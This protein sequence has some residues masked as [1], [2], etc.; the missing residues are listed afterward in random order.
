MPEE[1]LDEGHLDTEPPADVTF[2]P[3]GLGS[4]GDAAPA[5][6]GDAL[7]CSQTYCHGATLTG[8]TILAPR[9]N[10]V[11]GSQLACGKE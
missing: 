3:A 10:V 2:D 9:W 8:G 5:W 4:S 1:L 6:D 11:D 7:A